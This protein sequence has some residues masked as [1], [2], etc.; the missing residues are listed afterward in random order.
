MEL[1][2]ADPGNFSPSPGTPLNTGHM[3]TS[4]RF[5]TDHHL[6]PYLFHGLGLTARGGQAYT[7]CPFC[8]REQKFSI[9]L[10]TGLYRCLVCGVNGNPLV[11][12]RILYESLLL[13]S[14]TVVNNRSQPSTSV[15]PY[16]SI[17]DVS[18]G[19]LYSSSVQDGTAPGSPR[20]PQAGSGAGGVGTPYPARPDAP[21]A[22][23][24]D[25]GAT[26]R[27]AVAAD[28]RLLDPAT[29]AAWGLCPAR[30]GVWLVPGYGA[31]GKLDQVYRRV[32]VRDKEEWVW[33]LLPT[34][35]IWPEG[36]VHALHLPR[37]DF[38]PTRPDVVVCEGPWDGMAL[39][40]VWPRD[41]TANVVAVPGCTVWRDEWTALCRGKRVM[42]MYD[43]DHPRE[44]VP[45]HVSRAGYDGM[46]RVAKRLSGHAAQVRWLRWGPDGYD[47]SKPSGYDV[48]DFLSRM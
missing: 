19:K 10:S 41:N 11:F 13:A 3:P 30:D 46:V 20:T 12:V 15:P 33:C 27:A 39:W 43:S 25:P 1:W 45:G 28:R 29:V 6:R 24:G 32:R 38:D 31:D 37:G 4:V 5:T 9:Q 44:Y 47:P 8:G 2:R 7:D 34:P 35:G 16:S 14:C 18:S 21:A 42:L 48:R 23:L 17:Q 26:W 22:V 36:K 40:E